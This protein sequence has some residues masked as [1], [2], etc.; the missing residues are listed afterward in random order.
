MLTNRL[1]V[2]ILFAFGKS[3]KRLE[4]VHRPRWVLVCCV[5]HE[6]K[7]KLERISIAKSNYNLSLGNLKCNPL[8][9]YKHGYI[10]LS[11][12]KLVCV[13][14]FSLFI[15]LRLL[16]VAPSLAFAMHT[17]SKFTKHF[18]FSSAHGE[19]VAAHILLNL[20][21]SPLHRAYITFFQWPKIRSHLSAQRVRSTFEL[22]ATKVKSS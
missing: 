3:L 22:P 5:T 8:Q 10:D 11:T 20:A 2:K 16:L 17:N 15:L 4:T 13:C 21:F 14:I 18:Q 12:W 1:S 9:R 6:R 7:K 19:L